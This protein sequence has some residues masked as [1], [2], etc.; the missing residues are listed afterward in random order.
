MQLSHYLINVPNLLQF[1][2]TEATVFFAMNYR[3]YDKQFVCYFCTS[4]EKNLKEIYVYERYLRVQM[5]PQ[6]LT[7]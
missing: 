2:P 5:S 1:L 6:L 7:F 3:H 4:V